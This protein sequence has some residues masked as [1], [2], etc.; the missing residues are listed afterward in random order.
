MNDVLVAGVGM[1]PFK[2]P[3]DSGSYVEMGAQ[4]AHEAQGDAG[5]G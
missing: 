1:I 3:G 4:A 5:I 2:K